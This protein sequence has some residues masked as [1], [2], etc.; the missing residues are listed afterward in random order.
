MSLP[1][2]FPLPFSLPSRSACLLAPPYTPSE[3]E[4]GKEGKVPSRSTLASLG[5]RCGAATAIDVP[6][7]LER[8]RLPHAASPERG[9]AWPNCL[10]GF[11]N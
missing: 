2:P 3:R 11:G 6:F 4:G 5:G 7:F 1:A 8:A 10:N 9:L